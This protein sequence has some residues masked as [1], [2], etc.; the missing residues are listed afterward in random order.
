MG[1]PSELGRRLGAFRRRAGLSQTK[2]AKLSG[3]RRP[4]IS[5][6]ESGSQ[7]STSVDNLVKL[8]RVLSV[9]VDMLIHGDVL[10]GEDS[11]Q[12]EYAAAGAG[13]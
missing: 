1:E 12:S 8:A 13:V 6:L 7:S 4:T 11:Q 9:P 2:L 10:E 5:Y 3:V